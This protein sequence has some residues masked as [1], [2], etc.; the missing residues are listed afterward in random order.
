MYRVE[1]KV[2][3]TPQQTL[4]Y[5]CV[6]NVPCGVESFQTLLKSSGEGRFLMY[7][8]ELKVLPHTRSAYFRAVPNVPCGVESVDMNVKACTDILRS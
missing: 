3:Y 8:V 2:P 5:T 7:R 4:P 1:L 6:P